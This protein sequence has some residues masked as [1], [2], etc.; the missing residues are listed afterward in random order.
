MFDT[1]PS[2]VTE[3]SDPCWEMNPCHSLLVAATNFLFCGQ[4][5]VVYLP[6]P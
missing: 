2:V 4:Q 3:K 1:T 5:V 6:T